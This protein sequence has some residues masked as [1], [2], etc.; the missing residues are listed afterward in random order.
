MP[1]T[2]SILVIDQTD[3]LDIGTRNS[4]D[5]LE[6]IRNYMNG[7]IGGNKRVNSIRVFPDGTDNVYASGTVTIASGSSTV[8]ITINGVAIS[9]T[10]AT[11]DTAT[12]T[13]FVTDINGSANALVKNHVAASS[14]AGVV[15]LTAKAPG[16]WGNSVTLA[17][18][19][20]GMTA[21][22]ARLTGGA[23]AD[24]AAVTIS[25]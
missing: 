3:A 1:D 25:L 5:A 14:V 16:Q 23:G 10:W 11:S 4:K 22:G 7:A 2:A 9:R 17:A 8:S 15:K 6:I 13:A 20:T 19:G 24:S 12:A 21:S 18:S